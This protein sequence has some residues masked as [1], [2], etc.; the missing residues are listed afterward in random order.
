DRRAKDVKRQRQS[1]TL[2]AEKP[3]GDPPQSAS[4]PECEADERQPE[5]VFDEA[6]FVARLPRRAAQ[7]ARVETV[8]GLAEVVDRE[9]RQPLHRQRQS[10]QPIAECAVAV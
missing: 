8:F 9:Q 5:K 1:S 3:P 2:I 4:Q 10:S 7:A 6:Q